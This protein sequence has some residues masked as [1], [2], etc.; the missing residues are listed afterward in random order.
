LENFKLNFKE[1][2]ENNCENPGHTLRCNIANAQWSFWFV[3]VC[4]QAVQFGIWVW[5]I[6]RTFSARLAEPLTKSKN[7]CEH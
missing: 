7:P 5:L 2:L 6:S 3:N 4:K 1:F